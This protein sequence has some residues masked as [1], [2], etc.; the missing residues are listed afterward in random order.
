MDP[1]RKLSILKKAVVAEQ[2][3]SAELQA[4]LDR[5]DAEA[6]NAPETELPAVSEE[7]HQ[8]LL[9]SNERLQKR[10]LVLQAELAD[11]E[12]AAAAKSN[13]SLGSSIGWSSSSMSKAEGTKLQ[14]QLAVMEEQLELKIRENVRTT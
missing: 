12:K 2:K 7:D 3:K 1:D 11:K 8:R 9:F 14:E 13:W 5:R 10:V 6:K 4:E